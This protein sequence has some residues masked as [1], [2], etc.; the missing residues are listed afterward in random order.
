MLS[1]VTLGV[2]VLSVIMLKAVGM[3]VVAPIGMNRLVCVSINPIV[4]MGSY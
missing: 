2:I 1:F 3:I 4:L